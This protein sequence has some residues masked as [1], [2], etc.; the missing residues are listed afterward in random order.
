M[1]IVAGAVFFAVRALLALFPVLTVG[2]AIKKWAAAAALAA[3]AFYLALSGAEVATQRSFLMTAVVLV[4]VMVDRRA[5]TFRTLAVAALAVMLVAP[6]AVVHPSFQMS[7]AA[8]LGLV[9]L[10]DRDRALLSLADNSGV[11]RAALWG[12]REIALLLLASFVAGLAT[13]PYAAFHFH[14]AT[15]YGVLANLL[16][17]PVVSG[18]VMPAGLL[19]LLAMPFGFDGV[20][21][22]LMELGIAWMIAVS[23]W[24]A[25]LPGAVGR[26][27]AFGIAP[28]LL[29]T[30]GIV[31]IC[32][33]RTPLRWLGGLPVLL[34]TLLALSTPQPDILIASDGQSVA[35]RRADGIL[36]FMQTKKDVFAIKAWLAAD[37]DARA[38]DD[39]TLTRGARCDDA[40]CAVPM[41]DGRYVTIAKR[42]DAFADDC[43]KAAIIVTARQQ[44]PACKA[45]VFDQ[46]RLQ[47]TGSLALYGN[48]SAFAVQAV[49]PV[50]SNRPW[51]R[52]ALEADEAGEGTASRSPTSRPA[53]ATPAVEN[54]PPE[55]Q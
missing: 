38:V 4:G 14:R 17:M 35:I 26:I 53:D 52:N 36:S 30:L 24:V 8:T 46:Q 31:A 18:L 2:F 41:A 43:E 28:L 40:G 20:F 32:L 7:F 54:L 42:A 33:L 49:T 16:A 47:Q 9:A 6:E 48:G 21:W 23:Q 55:D 19:G 27:P 50:G 1:A 3:A 44:P 34:A 25:A 5:I 29:A 22:R 11:A 12:G 45:R 51:A 39:A 13:M 37:G 15:P 10:M